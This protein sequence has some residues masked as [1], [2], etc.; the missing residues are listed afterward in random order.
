MS[1][2]DN[3]VKQKKEHLSD[4][5]RQGLYKLEKEK[6]RLEKNAKRDKSFDKWDEDDDEY[7]D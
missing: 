4:R 6:K 7:K 5:D 2:G 3:K 1:N